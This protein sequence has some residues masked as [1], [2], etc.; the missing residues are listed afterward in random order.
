MRS[1]SQMRSKLTPL[2]LVTGAEVAEVSTKSWIPSSV[3]LAM[4]SPVPVTNIVS[5]YQA[6]KELRAAPGRAALITITVAMIAVM[7]TFLS[8]LA[9]GLSNQSVS[10]LSE[11]YSDDDAVVVSE[12]SSS[13][14]SSSVGTQVT[15]E[16]AAWAAAEG[17]NV[18]EVTLARLA[19][20][21]SP[22]P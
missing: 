18:R 10:A 4:F 7:V 14:A 13:L 2:S 6:M 15:D 22:S 16:V 9:A 19:W 21:R 3:S 12:G 1:P 8:A 11:V 20:V 17:E 5:M